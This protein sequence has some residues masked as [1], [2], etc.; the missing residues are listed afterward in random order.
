MFCKTRQPK[1]VSRSVIE[2][3][4]LRNLFGYWSRD[5]R[6]EVRNAAA[7]PKHSMVALL[8]ACVSMCECMCMQECVGLCVRVCVCACVRVCACVFVFRVKVLIFFSSTVSVLFGGICIVF[9]S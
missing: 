2:E 4:G 7:T 6:Q 5:E 1:L 9:S 8:C 3:A